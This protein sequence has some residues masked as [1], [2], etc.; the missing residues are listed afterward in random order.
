MLNTVYLGII[1]VFS[2]LFPHKE[3]KIALI[4]AKGASKGYKNRVL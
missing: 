4:P 2:P 3:V 1:L